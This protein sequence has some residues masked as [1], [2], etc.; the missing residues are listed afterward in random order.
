MKTPRSAGEPLF[1][2]A[3]ITVVISGS[4]STPCLFRKKRRGFNRGEVHSLRN[5]ECIYIVT[6][7]LDEEQAAIRSRDIIKLMETI[8][9]TIRHT[10]SWGKRKLAYEV[11]KQRFGY[12]FLVHLDCD[13]TALREVDR[14]L[15]LHEDVIKYMIVQL[16]PDR[17]GKDSALIQKVVEPVRQEA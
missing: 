8:G 3:T 17:V 4:I 7:A 9:A 13:N 15:K 6:P 2:A 5:Y 12:Y 10:E 14:N 1:E 11:K 16:E